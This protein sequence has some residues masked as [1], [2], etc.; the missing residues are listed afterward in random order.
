MR[1]P[2][3]MSGTPIMKCLLEGIEDKACVCRPARPPANDAT[4]EDVNHRGHAEEALP[5]RDLRDV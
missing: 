3:A 1:E 2:A 4:S 5:G